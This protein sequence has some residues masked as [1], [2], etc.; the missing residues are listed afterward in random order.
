MFQGLGESLDEAHAGVFMVIS[1]VVV[2]EAFLGTSHLRT[3]QMEG[4]PLG[5]ATLQPSR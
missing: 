5:L 3:L 4:V 2:V 1:R